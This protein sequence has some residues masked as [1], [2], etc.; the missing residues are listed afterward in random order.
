[1]AISC[2]SALD[3]WQIRGAGIELFPNGVSPTTSFGHKHQEQKLNNEHT[4]WL[5]CICFLSI[6][7]KSVFVLSEGEVPFIH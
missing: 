4:L 7:Q 5:S 3:K 2:K 1:M 6:L